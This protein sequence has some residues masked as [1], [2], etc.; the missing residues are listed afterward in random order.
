MASGP[1]SCSPWASPD[2]PQGWLHPEPW[3]AR[4]AAQCTLWFCPSLP[5]QD[6]AARPWHGDFLEEL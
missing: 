6:Q 2:D 3:D 5:L 4:P 1:P